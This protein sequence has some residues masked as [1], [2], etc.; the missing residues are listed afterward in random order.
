MKECDNSHH[1]HPKH[2]GLGHLAR[3]V[4]R[5]K[6]A[7]SIVSLVSQ[8][9]NFPVGCKGMILKV[10]DFVTFF[11]GVKASSFCIHLSCLVCSLFVVRGEWSRCF[12]VIKGVACQRSQ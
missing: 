6:F 12:V 10:F 2:P 4:S 8:L 7:L 9:F 3:S 5:V 11:E 1:R